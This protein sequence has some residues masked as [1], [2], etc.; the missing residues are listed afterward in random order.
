MARK[1]TPEEILTITRSFQP[2][3]VIFAAADLN[4]FSVFSGTPL[5]ATTISQKLETD[6]RATT[7]LLDALVSLEL[8]SKENDKYSISDEV[9]E[10]LSDNG[11]KSITGGIRH[12]ANC[13]RRWIQLPQVVKSGKSAQRTP[14]IRGENQDQAAFIQAM[15]NFSVPIADDLI[16]KIK[17]LNFS[18][19]L[20]V[21]VLRDMD[22]CIFK[23]SS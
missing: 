7:V 15:D 6:L 9:A 12:L 16:R 2:A 20:D 10:M 3:C 21:G 11:K 4:V 23:S 18:H 5:D 17:P 1:W 8:L 13:M 14:S 22:Y 19:L